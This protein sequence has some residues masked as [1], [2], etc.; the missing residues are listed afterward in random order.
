MDCGSQARGCLMEKRNVT[1][2]T[3]R[4]SLC[5]A[6]SEKL[7]LMCWIASDFEKT[8]AIVAEV[9]GFDNVA[10]T[11]F[12]ACSSFA[13]KDIAHSNFSFRHQHNVQRQTAHPNLH[14]RLY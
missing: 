7:C 13:V 3:R 12:P 2:T 9:P 14:R 4:A 6:A 11:E 5:A 1:D 8:R 10:L